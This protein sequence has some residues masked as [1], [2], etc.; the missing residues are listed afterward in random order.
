MAGQARGAERR[1]ARLCGHMSGM[2]PTASKENTSGLFSKLYHGLFSR[3][4]MTKCHGGEIVARV[5]KAHGCEFVFTLSGGHISPIL[6]ASEAQGVPRVVDVRNEATAVFAAD[7]VARLTG[8]PGV[9][10]VTAGPGVTNT[11]TALKNAQ[12]AQSPVVLIGGAAATITQGLGAL[13]DIDQ[14]SILK[15]IVKRVFNIKSVRDIAPQLREALRLS[16]SGVPG[17][18]F[19]QLALDVLYPPLETAAGMGL[20]ARMRASDVRSESDFSKVIVPVESTTRNPREYV[21]DLRPAEPVFLRQDKSPNPAVV[22]KYL[23]FVHNNIYG[24][25]GLGSDLKIASLPP[26]PLDIPMADSWQIEKALGFLAS[27]KRP[28]LVLGSQAVVG[29]PEAATRLAAA[30]KRMGVPAFLGG[31]SRGLLGRNH[32]LHIRQNR[33]Q[34]LK[35]SDLVILL[36]SVADFRLDY[37]RKLPTASRANVVAVSRSREQ[38]NLNEGMLGFWKAAMKVE[39]DPERFFGA[40]EGKVGADVASRFA[41]WARGLKEAEVRVEEKNLKKAAQPAFGRKELVDGKALVNPMDLFFKLE[42][43][44]PKNSIL[45][46]DGGDFV[47]TG[48]YILRPRGPLSWLDPG[49]YG[50]LGVGAGFALGAKLARPDAQV[51]LLW[52]DGSAGYSIAEFDTFKRHKVPVIGL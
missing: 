45:V 6:A 49:A 37:G 52:G 21:K 35:R 20:L 18:V 36:G 1:L 24:G 2:E 15:P 23:R 4:P 47:A 34:A 8:Y 41:G 26:L 29:G 7:A 5:L 33:T 50:T 17:P 32:P 39:S 43:L 13:Q 27:A 46:A 16:A 38:L 10:C 30:I 9:A 44:L 42:S 40:L 31:M 48:S 3:A 19:V 28:V 51:W 12:M 11:I 25:A 14:I 22:D